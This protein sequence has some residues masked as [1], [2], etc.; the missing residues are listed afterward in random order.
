[1]MLQA[2]RG[3]QVFDGHSLRAGV[4][5]VQD[6]VV[7]DIAETVPFGATEIPLPGGILA[8]GLIDL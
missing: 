1:M 7:L 5:V 4:V 3:A 8:P 6:G 2:F